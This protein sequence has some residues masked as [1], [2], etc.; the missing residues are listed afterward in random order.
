LLIEPFGYCPTLISIM[1]YISMLIAVSEKSRRLD[2]PL[3]EL[4]LFSE[5]DALCNLTLVVEDKTLYIH[6]EVSNSIH[7]S[8][9]LSITY[10][11]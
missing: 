11:H 10:S 8:T 6:K 5:P 9:E 3:P 1:R 7:R 4:R 2:K